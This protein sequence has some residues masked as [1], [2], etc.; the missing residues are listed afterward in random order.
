[1]AKVP[2]RLTTARLTLRRPVTSDAAAAFTWASDA[3][4]TRHMGWPTHKTIDDTLAFM[5]FA[6]GEWIEKGVG[7]Y[8]IEYGGRVVGSTGLHLFNRHRAM[9]GYILRRDVWGQG[10]ATEACTAMV[11]LGRS[12]GIAR[13]EAHCHLEHV[14]SSR[15]LEKSGLQFEAVLRRFLVFPNISPRPEDVRSYAAVMD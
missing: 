6:T 2:E 1:M 14:A 4:V 13:I 3:E 5:S 15:V 12:L 7:T 9:T 11:E 8:F 10:I